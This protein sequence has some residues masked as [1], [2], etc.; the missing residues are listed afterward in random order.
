[1]L[2]Y[3][4]P[5]GFP[6]LGLLPCHHGD[7]FLQFRIKACV[8]FTPPL[9]RSPSVLYQT[10]DRLIPEM[11]IVS[12]FDD[13]LHTLDASSAVLY[14]YCCRT[15]QATSEKFQMLAG[16][17]YHGCRP[18]TARDAREAFKGARDCRHRTTT[19]AQIFN[20][21]AVNVARCVMTPTQ[22]ISIAIEKIGIRN[23]ADSSVPGRQTAVSTSSG[24]KGP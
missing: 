15:G 11:L 17:L 23:S 1:M 4:G 18:S 5:R 12:G 22:A 2:R 3:S 10:S 9:R 19:W 6:P 8:S 24:K 21:V 7:W 16:P 14:P 13:R 20:K